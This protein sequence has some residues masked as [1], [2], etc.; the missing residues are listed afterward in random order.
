MTAADVTVTLA[1]RPE[2]AP[3]LVQA[4]VSLPPELRFP[5]QDR[6]TSATTLVTLE[7]NLVG[8][9]FVVVCGDASNQNA[10]P[11]PSGP[12]FRVRVAPSSPRVPGTYNVTLSELKAATQDGQDVPLLAETVTVAV[13]VR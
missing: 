10:S 5:Q 3:A 12:L 11:L 13:T 7:G 9:D 6:L 2:P 1:Q 8:P 4:K